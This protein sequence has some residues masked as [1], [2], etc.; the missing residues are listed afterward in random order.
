MHSERYLFDQVRNPAKCYTAVAP[1]FEESRWRWSIDLWGVERCRYWSRLPPCRSY[2]RAA[3]GVQGRGQ[4]TVGP[5]HTF[6]DDNKQR[7]NHFR[8][9]PGQLPGRAVRTLTTRESRA[10][11]PLR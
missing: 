4:E 2:F 7:L 11:L 5:C 6:L 3:Y 8:F 9:P 1:A 10:Q